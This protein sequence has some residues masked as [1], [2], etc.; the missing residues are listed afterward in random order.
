MCLI[1]LHTDCVAKASTL[2]GAMVV[3]AGS[4]V[5]L[6]LPS[7]PAAPTR[8]DFLSPLSPL[9]T[10]PAECVVSGLFF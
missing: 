10:L 6:D 1:R 7:A 4:Q 8:M 3:T 5:C 2:I 9:V